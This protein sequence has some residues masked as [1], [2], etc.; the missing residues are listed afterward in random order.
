MKGVSK[1]KG[2]NNYWRVRY[3]RNIDR[4]FSDKNDAI[5]FRKACEK[6]TP[7]KVRHPK[8][9]YI[10]KRFKIIGDTGKRHNGSVVYVIKDLKTNEYFESIL[11]NLKASNPR[12]GRG[13]QTKNVH[14]NISKSSSGFLF[15]KT[16]NGQTIQKYFHT[17]PEALTYR[18]QWLT[19]HNLPIPD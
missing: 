15:K 16:V 1:V 19:D 13:N 2:R 4:Y 7:L 17:L 10:N 9:N 6:E 18:N 8:S 11:Q 14:A 3:G 5:A 12:I